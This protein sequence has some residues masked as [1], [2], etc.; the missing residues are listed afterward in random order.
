MVW[1][2]EVRLVLEK[3]GEVRLGKMKWE[4]RIGSEV[5]LNLGIGGE[6]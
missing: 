1:E 6:V 4:F 2:K 5:R 3:G